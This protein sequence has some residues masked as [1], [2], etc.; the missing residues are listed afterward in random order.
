MK[1]N[2]KKQTQSD[3][4]QDQTLISKEIEINGLI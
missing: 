4:E 1:C 3:I 2:P